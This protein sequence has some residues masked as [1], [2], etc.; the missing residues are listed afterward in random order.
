MFPLVLECAD[1]E[2]KIDSPRLPQPWLLPNRRERVVS[3]H[4][5][6]DC[7]HA[8]RLATILVKFTSRVVIIAYDSNACKSVGARC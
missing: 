8:P 2:T 4:D 1:S 7:F 3:L 6:V 5:R